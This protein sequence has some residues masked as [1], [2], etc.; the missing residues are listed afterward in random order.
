MSLIKEFIYNIINNN[1]N[2]IPRLDRGIQ[3]TLDCPVKPEN[4][5]LCN[6]SVVVYKS[7]QK[8]CPPNDR[9]KNA[10]Y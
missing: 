9:E 3:K 7:A 8:L 1:N 4:D 2:V 10:S 5:R 6:N